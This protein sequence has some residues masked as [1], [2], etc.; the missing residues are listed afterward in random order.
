MKEGNFVT[1]NKLDQ[2]KSKLKT[3]TKERER[4]AA[5]SASQAER[6]EML[7]MKQTLRNSEKLLKTIAV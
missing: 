7:R 1:V 6:R 3:K 4:R 2:M 5:E